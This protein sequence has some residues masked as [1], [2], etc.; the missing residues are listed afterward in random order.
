MTPEQVD[1]ETAISPTVAPAHARRASANARAGRGAPTVASGRTSSAA[2]ETRSLPNELSPF[3]RDAA[4]SVDLLAQPKMSR[5]G[6]QGRA[7][8]PVKL[9]DLSP[10]TNQPVRLLQGRY[11]SLFGRRRD[12][13]FPSSRRD[14][15]RSDLRVCS[16]SL[17]ERADGRPV[18]ES[19][20]QESRAEGRKRTGEEDREE[21]RGQD[22]DTQEEGVKRP[23]EHRCPSCKAATQWS[24]AA[25]SGFVM[26]ATF[27]PVLPVSSRFAGF[28][29]KI[30]R[31]ARVFLL[32]MGVKA[33]R[34]GCAAWEHSRRDWPE[35]NRPRLPSFMMPGADR[36]GHYLA[37]FRL[38]SWGRTLEDALQENLYPDRPDAARDSPKSRILEA[39]P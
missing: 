23:T 37:W 13:R 33:N 21:D 18:E 39:Y 1:L 34:Q 19:N 2:Q 3:G 16:E 8:E 35:A 7:K 26:C 5:G 25:G 28:F 9:F 4:T 6:G 20:P 12:Q 15:R 30:C 29:N 38:G 14:D 22:G 11:G 24:R 31:P 27:F 17:E 32:E 36:V 10:V